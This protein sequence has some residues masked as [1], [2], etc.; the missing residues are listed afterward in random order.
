MKRTSLEKL[1]RRAIKAGIRTSRKV[2]HTLNREEILAL[3]VQVIPLA[4]RILVGIAAIVLVIF[5][6]AGW[7]SD[8]NIVQGI[9]VVA[10]LFLGLFA[11]FGVKRTLG[12]IFD[13]AADLNALD[14]IID[15]LSSLDL[16]L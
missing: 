2:R 5:G 3:R 11:L 12:T 4:P 7:P 13:G 6:C 16:D 9:E 8:S 1:Q 15:V 14:G 10:G